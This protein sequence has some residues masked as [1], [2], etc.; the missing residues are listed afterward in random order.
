MAAWAAGYVLYLV[1]AL[2]WGWQNGVQ[3]YLGFAV[4]QAVLYAPLWPIVLFAQFYK[5]LV[6]L[7]VN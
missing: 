7:L 1:P 2:L 5:V 6:P 3:P 4:W